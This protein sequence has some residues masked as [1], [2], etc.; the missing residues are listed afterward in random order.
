MAVEK[1]TDA[2][3][4]D[5]NKDGQIDLVVVGEWMNPTFLENSKGNFKDVT[6]TFVKGNNSGLWQSI[7]AFDIDNDGDDDFILGNFGLNSKFKASDKYPMKMYVG[8]LDN[9][10]RTETIIA[11]E[12]KGNY[13]TLQGLDELAGQLNY[14][15]KKYRSYKDFAGKT[16]EEIFGKELLKTTTL[17]K[18]TN[19]ASGYLKNDEGSFTFYPFMDANLQLSPITEILKYDFNADGQ[20]DILVAG[21][22]FGVTPYQG[23]FDSFAGA[24]MQNNGEVVSSAKVGVDFFNKAVKGLNIINYKGSKY[25]LVTINN[26]EIEIYEIPN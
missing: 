23:R 5:F 25:L 11:I 21:N 15:K 16:V 2:I 18:V 14:L 13:Y 24:V 4:T 6:S 17:L 10:N 22:Y 9:N 19:L 12:K 8:D 20:D 7:A 1:S 26:D 3:S